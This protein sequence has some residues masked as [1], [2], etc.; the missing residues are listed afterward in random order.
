MQVGSLP[1]YLPA[2]E[3]GH[4]LLLCNVPILL[5]SVAAA[6]SCCRLP[7]RCRVTLLCLLPCSV[8]V[9]AFQGHTD[10]VMRAAWSPDGRLV[11]SGSSDGVVHLWQPTEAA[12]A[13]R[14]NLGHAGTRQLASLEVRACYGH[15]GCGRGGVCAGLCCA[16]AHPSWTFARVHTYTPLPLPWCL[17]CR[18][19]RRRCMPAPSSHP[20][21]LAAL[22]ASGW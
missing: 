12:L 2:A 9:A 4:V 1:A 3:A 11:A 13:A 20:A 6:G 14:H 7:P 15:G 16:P 18:A 17:L 19:T 5:L 10:S 8:Q 22:A 21:A